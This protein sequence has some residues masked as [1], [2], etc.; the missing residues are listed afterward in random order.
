[1]AA[2]EADRAAGADR[3]VGADRAAGADRN[4]G[5]DRAAGAD[6][7]AGADADLGPERV[8]LCQAP[9][10]DT[11]VAGAGVRDGPGGGEI[12]GGGAVLESSGSLTL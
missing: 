11:S 5:A 2:G 10:S 1:M 4:V 6:R 12:R 3:N 7:I 8:V 9:G